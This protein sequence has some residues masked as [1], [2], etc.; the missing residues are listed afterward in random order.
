LAK[1]GR[2][3]AWKRT[4]SDKWGDKQEKRKAPP[5][6]PCTAMIVRRCAGVDDSRRSLTWLVRIRHHVGQIRVIAYMAIFVGPQHLIA[7]HQ[8]CAG[9]EQRITYWPADTMSLEGGLQPSRQGPWSEELR[10]GP[11]TETKCSVKLFVRI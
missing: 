3:I 8:K 9:H 1:P 4:A 5:P 10:H 7:T 2:V 6:L 11:A